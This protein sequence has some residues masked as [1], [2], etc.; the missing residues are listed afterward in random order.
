MI[1]LYEVLEVAR[2]ADT[3]TIKSAWRKLA[4]LHHPDKHGGDDSIFKEIQQAYDVLG[5]AE[6]RAQYD[7]TGSTTPMSSVEAV[8]RTALAEMINKAIEAVGSVAEDELEYHDPV[9]VVR[10]ELHGVRKTN[11]EVRDKV[12]RKIRQRRTAL[13][14]LVRKEGDGPSVLADAVQGA[15]AQLEGS[16]D[17]IAEK[18][19]VILKVLDLLAEYDYTTDERK[20]EPR[21]EPMSSGS[22]R[23]PPGPRWGGI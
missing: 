19:V 22:W 10:D 17:Q 6:R 18:D 2:D 11:A 8:A 12:Q 20:S 14:R 4:Q 16:L 23:Q 15:I 5:D 1:D 9:Q 21:W 3:R 7:E 13:E